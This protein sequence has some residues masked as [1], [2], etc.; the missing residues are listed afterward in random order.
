MSLSSKM[1]KRIRSIMEE[2]HISAYKLSLE[3]GVSGAC[4]NNWLNNND[5]NPT[6]NNIEKVASALGVSVV[7][8]LDETEI[9]CIT[10][11]GVIVNTPTGS[12]AYSLSVGGSILAPGINA[13]AVTPIASHSFSQRPVIFSSKNTCTLIYKKGTSAGV[14]VDGK[15]IRSLDVNDKILIKEADFPTI[16]LRKKDSNFFKRLTDKLKYRQRGL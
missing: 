12:T 13:F 1:L 10:G 16:F 6:I 15:F 3:S 11:D 4:L 9:D 7:D 2:N 8:L 5:C 14:F